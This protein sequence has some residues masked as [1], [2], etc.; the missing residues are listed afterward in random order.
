M[1]KSK[2]ATIQYLGTLIIEQNSDNCAQSDMQ[3]AITY[4]HI[5]SN[6]GASNSDGSNTMDGSN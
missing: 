3:L 4:K 1:V 5:Q 6:F 2:T